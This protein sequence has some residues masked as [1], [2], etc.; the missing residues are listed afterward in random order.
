MGNCGDLIEASR[1]EQCLSWLAI[2]RV[3]P[4]SREPRARRA[5]RSAASGPRLRVSLSS[6]RSPTRKFVA[7]RNAG[8]LARLFACAALL[9]FGAVTLAWW[10]FLAWLVWRVI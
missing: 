7:H 3:G 9:V 1:D 6:T 4:Q 10:G 2:P 5:S 8:N